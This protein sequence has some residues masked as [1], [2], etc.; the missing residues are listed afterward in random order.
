MNMIVPFSSREDPL[1]MNVTNWKDIN[2]YVYEFD[3]T[4]NTLTMFCRK[5]K[6]GS[7]TGLDFYYIEDKFHILNFHMIKINDVY[8]YFRGCAVNLTVKNSKKAKELISEFYLAEYNRTKEEA[9]KYKR[10]SKNIN[11]AIVKKEK[12]I[13]ETTK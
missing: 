4:A 12:S 3:V 7:C 10:Y 11:D 9:N 13:D 2:I 8:P 6:H 1:N 5:G